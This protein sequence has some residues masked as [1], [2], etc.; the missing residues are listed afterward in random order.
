MG[1]GRGVKE[2]QHGLANDAVNGIVNVVSFAVKSSTIDDHVVSFIRVISEWLDNITYDVV[3]NLNNPRQATR[4]VSV[5]PNVSFKYTKQIYRCVSNKN[6][7][8]SS[9][10]K[11]QAEVARQVV[12]NSNLFDALNSIENDDDLGTNEGNSI[13]DR[14]GVASSSISS[15]PIA[16]R[17]DKIKRQMIIG[18]LLLVDDDGKPLPKVVSMVNTYSDSEVE[19]V[20]NEHTT[21]MQSTSLKRGSDSGYG[22][23]NLWEQ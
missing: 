16:K 5:G 8:S 14:K 21:F 10:E 18:K 12:S 9:G 20:F 22:T 3:K 4:D 13:L 15:T 7:A 23:N 11:K 1:W 19:E 6:D 17:I 2:K